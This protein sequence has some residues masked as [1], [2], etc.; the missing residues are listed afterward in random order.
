MRAMTKSMRLHLIICSV[1]FL[2][3]QIAWAEPSSDNDITVVMDCDKLPPSASIEVFSWRETARACQQMTKILQGVRIKDIRNFEKGGFLLHAKNCGPDTAEQ[4]VGNLVEIVRR[5]GL[6]DK[7]DRW[8]G[9]VDLV[10]R[11]C[12]AF[13]GLVTSKDVIEFLK[14]SGPMSK[15]LSDDGLLKM[16]IVVKQM[17]QRGD[18]D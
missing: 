17:R 15:T 4:G 8:A 5:R 18:S 13:K 9:T 11:V 6:F 10:W 14:E 2:S 3:T 12:D 7:P 16:L 1:I